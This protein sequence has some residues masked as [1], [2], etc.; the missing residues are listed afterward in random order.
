[1]KNEFS[2]NLYN[3][4]MQ[5]GWS[6]KETAGNLGIS[7]ALLSHYEK[8]IRECGLDFLIK[9]SEVFNCTTDYLLG[10]SGTPAVTESSDAD[11]ISADL[12]EFPNL[13]K[14]RDEIQDTVNILYSI[15]ARIGNPEICKNFNKYFGNSLYAELRSLEKLYFHKENFSGDK[16]L[17]LI[18]AK[19]K[20]S[21]AYYAIIRE[22][23]EKNINVNLKT[24]RIKD[25]YPIRSKAFFN[26][27]SHFE[28]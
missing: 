4:R 3:L 28:G 26:L 2:K 12:K 15:T 7:Q 16:D 18:N 19:R 22:M 6:Q 10:I 23:Q 13:I 27:I 1:M 25:E 5:R 14:S 20:A 24:I 11:S 9:A 17:S 21:T 8:G